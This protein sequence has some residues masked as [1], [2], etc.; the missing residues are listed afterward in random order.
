MRLRCCCVMAA[1]RAS[2]CGAL[3]CV[4][5][6]RPLAP[7]TARDVLPPPP[8]LATGRGARAHGA[9]ACTMA[10]IIGRCTI[11]III[12]I[13]THVITPIV[14]HRVHSEPGLHPVGVHPVRQR[15][16]L[17]RR[18]FAR[19]HGQTNFLLRPS[20]RSR[21]SSPARAVAGRA[22]LRPAP[23]TSLQVG[24]RRGCDRAAARAAAAEEPAQPDLFRPLLWLAPGHGQTASAFS[25]F[26]Q[27]EGSLHV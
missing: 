1:I 10:I 12:I 18:R 21:P 23:I 6:A 13:I 9:R 8:S 5:A 11:A 22:M 3:V 24:R 20:R 26:R 27:P 4:G 15:A 14:L 25:Q 16:A 17:R 7:G 19:E 2:T